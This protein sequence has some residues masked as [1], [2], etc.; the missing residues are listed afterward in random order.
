MRRLTLLVL[1]LAACG[2]DSNNRK[3]IDAPHVDID[4][5][6]L[7]SAL[8]NPVTVTVKNQPG[9]T[10]DV[11][12]YF[13]NADSTL[14]ATAHTDAN[15]TA[16]QV[17]AA[18]GFVSLINPYVNAGVGALTNYTLITWAG[19]KPGD[20]LVIDNSATVAAATVTFNLPLDTAHGMVG[21]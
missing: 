16:S 5:K 9:P 13:Q 4:G 19:V 20:H 8:P 11:E 6:D 10:A 18:G 14:V 21:S 1:A 15:G 2:D 7:D 17:M 3:I 12:V